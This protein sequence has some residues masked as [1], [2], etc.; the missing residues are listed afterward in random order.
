M[1][2]GSIAH[3]YGYGLCPGPCPHPRPSGPPRR[4]GVTADQRR[5]IGVVAR[6]L[7][8]GLRLHRWR[9][10]GLPRCRESWPRGAPRGSPVRICAGQD[11]PPKGRSGTN[12]DPAPRWGAFS[13]CADAGWFHRP[14][15]AG[16]TK[17]AAMFV[18]P[19][20][21][22]RWCAGG[23]PHSRES[24]PQ[25]DG[26][27]LIRPPRGRDPAYIQQRDTTAIVER[28]IGGDGCSVSEC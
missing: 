18:A 24:R 1:R 14:R 12:A 13:W 3:G 8:G 21:R 28:L 6:R 19:A 4:F 10:G 25:H 9:A 20:S 2:F 15:D 5:T 17:D 27:G 11:A 16:A 22:R 7:R 23:L 26:R